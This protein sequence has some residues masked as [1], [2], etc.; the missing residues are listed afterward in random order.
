MVAEGTRGDGVAAAGLR[1]RVR[2]V[3]PVPARHREL[4]VRAGVRVLPHRLP[5]HV[6]RQVLSGA[7]PLAYTTHGC[8]CSW[9]DGSYPQL[10]LPP[11]GYQLARHL[12]A[13]RQP[14][15]LTLSLLGV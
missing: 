9:M 5:L 4:Q 15:D 8:S 2:A 6:P 3:L 1:A 10:F 14:F 7:L 12:A 11:F 13:W